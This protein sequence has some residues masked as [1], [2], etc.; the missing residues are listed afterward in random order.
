MI[1]QCEFNIG[2]PK[3]RHKEKPTVDCKGNKILNTKYEVLQKK[4][5]L[6][7]SKEIS[8][9]HQQLAD[10]LGTAREVVSR[11]LKQ[12]EREK[13]IALSRNKITIL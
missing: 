7:G 5:Q 13:K 9:T 4:Q 3:G 10:E 1:F 12:L 8:V 11:L 6:T 2:K